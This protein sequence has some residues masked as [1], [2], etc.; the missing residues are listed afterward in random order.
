METHI[1]DGKTLTKFGDAQQAKITYDKMRQDR[2]KVLFSRGVIIQIF[3]GMKK[4]EIK[5]IIK[6]D[7]L[8]GVEYTTNIKSKI[9]VE[10]YT[11]EVVNK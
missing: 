8:K 5:K 6:E 11:E 4:E 2:K 1:F 10:D 3:R 7:M 9:T